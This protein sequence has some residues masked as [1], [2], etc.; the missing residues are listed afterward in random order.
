[1]ELAGCTGAEVFDEQLRE[2]EEL[3]LVALPQ[4]SALPEIMVLNLETPE[5]SPAPAP[6]VAACK[7][8]TL[9]AAHGPVVVHTQTTIHFG[10]HKGAESGSSS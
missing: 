9:T 7:P 8:S 4:D 1:M 3:R 2:L 6:S 10:G 5:N